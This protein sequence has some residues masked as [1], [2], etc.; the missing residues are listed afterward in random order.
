MDGTAEVIIIGGG[1]IGC[2]IAYHLARIGCRN[3]IILERNYIGSGSTE[4]CAG[5]VR[6]QFSSEVNIRLSMKSVKFFERFEEETG[7]PA[8]FHQHGYLIL[9]TSPEEVATFCQNVALQQSLGLKVQLLSPQEAKEIVPE[10]N[11]EDV[12]GA[13]FC[14]TDGYADPYSVTQ[15][16][17]SA[18]R[19]LGVKIFEETTV[20]AIKVVRGRPHRILTN[21]GEFEAPVVVNAAGAYA[22]QIGKM[23]NLDI[24]IR[25]S[26]RHIFVTTPLDAVPKD[27]PMIIELRSGFWFR[28]EGPGLIFG[29][30]N[31]NE[32]EGFDA[33]VDWDFLANSLAEVAC[34]RLPFLNNTGIVRGQAGLHSDTPDYHA[35]LGPVPK[36]KGLY[37]ACGFSGHGFMHSPAVGRLM[38]RLILGRRPSLNISQFG[39]ERFKSLHLQEERIFV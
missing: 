27:I 37:L 5:G 19:R 28:K 26:R 7:H 1:V 29:M 30:R 18:A 32:P 23:V 17:A 25:P 31:A 21:Q 22:A 12:L 33:S 38:A 8:D 9:A 34:H 13:T 6:Q 14:P 15:G 24:P 2:S 11:V 16:F 20:I 39:L 3:V 10:L 36:I 35:I 4:K